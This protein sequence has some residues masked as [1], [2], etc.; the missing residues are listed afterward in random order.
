MALATFLDIEFQ[1][2]S[3]KPL[4]QAS[5]WQPRNKF[6]FFTA[7]NHEILAEGFCD[8]LRKRLTVAGHIL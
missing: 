3:S 4:L 7:Y 1:G 6:S 2:H 8:Y 5:C